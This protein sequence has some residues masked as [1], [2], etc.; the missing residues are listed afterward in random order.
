VFAVAVAPLCHPV[1]AVDVSPAML[2]YMR[3]EVARLGIK[4][5]EAVSGGFLSYEHTG[6][7]VDFVY[8]RNVLHQVPDFLLG[9]PGGKRLG[10][11]RQ[12]PRAWDAAALTGRLR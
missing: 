1:I 3:D 10:F 9:L 4:N 11:M 2:A 8:T 6:E 5:V 12:S 7:P